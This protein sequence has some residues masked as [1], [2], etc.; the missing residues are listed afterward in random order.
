MHK[1]RIQNVP[2]PCLH[3]LNSTF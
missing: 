2:S 3:W 1:N